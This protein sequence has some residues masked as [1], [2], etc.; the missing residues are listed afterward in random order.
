MDVSQSTVLAAAAAGLGL[1]CLCRNRSSADAAVGPAALDADSAAAL[2]KQLVEQGYCVVPAA[3]TRCE[4]G[5]IGVTCHELLERPE[6]QQFQ[7]DK[8]TGSLVPLS[9]HE[10]FANLIAHEAT[11]GALA[12]LGF[13]PPRWLSGFIISKPPGG[14]SLGWHQDGWY[15]DEDCAYEKYPVQLFA[16]YYLQ[17]TTRSNGC[18]RCIPG[19]HLKEQPLHKILGAAHSTAVRETDHTKDPAHGDPP[20]AVDIEVKAGDLVLGDARV[21]HAAHANNSDKRRTLITM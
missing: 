12:K 13:K 5:E 20:G 17:D 1:A 10:R 16:M 9:K 3:M 15:W 11:L 4:I 8:F 18:L 21:L 7:E 14:P 2:K 6:N 19:S